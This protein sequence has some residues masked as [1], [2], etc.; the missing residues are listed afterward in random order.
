M[1]TVQITQPEDD[2]SDLFFIPKD[3]PRKP[4]VIFSHGSY[5]GGY[6]FAGPILVTKT[7]VSH[8]LGVVASRDVKAGECLFVTRP[9][10]ACDISVVFKEWKTR[11]NASVSGGGSS[12]QQ[13]NAPHT[14][15][16]KVAEAV[17]VEAMKQKLRSEDKTDR[18]NARS[19]LMQLSQT[20]KRMAHSVQLPENQAELVA[21]LAGNPMDDPSLPTTEG[22]MDDT[23]L[24]GIIRRNSF[25]P[26]FVSYEI[27][28]AQW[29]KN[30]EENKPPCSPS[31]LLGLYPLAAMINHSCIPNALR[32]FAGGEWMVVHASVNINKGEEILWSYVP[33]ILTYPR[34]R[35]HLKKLHD[36]ICHCARCEKE[37]EAASCS[38]IYAMPQSL[39][40]FQGYTG[41]VSSSAESRH[42]FTRDLLEWEERNFANGTNHSNEIR[43]FWKMGNANLFINYLNAV[44]MD[45][46]SKA[47]EDVETLRANLVVKAMELHFC[48]VSCHFACTEHLS[49]MHLCYELV[50]ILHS[51][52]SDPGKTISKVKFWTEQ[53]KRA[54]MIRYGCLGH[55]VDKVRAIMK[56]TQVVLRN[57]NGLDSVPY[58]FI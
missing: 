40:P 56:H 9:A 7:G 2:L 41:N 42:Q 48:F 18:A 34:R 46:S 17:L 33:P 54:H 26:D 39:K 30:L 4:Q 11:Y 44:L 35:Q 31:R 5:S 58:D 22:D 14:L 50:A 37:Q 36:F 13:E 29:K 15:L 47:P 32:V 52:S 20:D 57:Q 53:L 24:L 3:V 51:R 43:R 1:D 55:D 16:E 25:G 21:A 10:V 12:N 23:K 45:L 27:V 8:G 49:V 6:Y 19:F 38:E 28:E